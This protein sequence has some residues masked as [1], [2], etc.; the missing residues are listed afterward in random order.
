MS[1]ASLAF[2]IGRS[3][4][5]LHIPP[6]AGAT[7]AHPPAPAQPAP[8]HDLYARAVSTPV[9]SAPLRHRVRPGDRV[10]VL[11]DDATRPTPT[12]DLFAWLVAD[13]L[14]SGVRE[15][16][17][18]PVYAPGL[19]Q[20]DDRR[21][22]AKYGTQLFGHPRLVR[23]DFRR[24][25]LVFKGV[26]SRGV[27]VFVNDVLDQVDLAISLGQITPHMDAGFGGGGKIILPGISGKP[28]VEQNH[29][30][31]LAPGSRLAR[32]EGNPV[33][34]DM[35][36]AAALTNLAFIINTITDNQGQVAHVTAGHPLAAHRAGAAA[37]LQMLGHHIPAPVDI[38]VV[39]TA[40]DYLLAAM[41]PML[42][43]DRAVKL[44]GDI[45]VAA[46][47]RLGWAAQPDVDAEL[48]PEERLMRQSAAELARIVAD[49]DVSALRLA[50]TVFNYRR[51]ALEKTVTLV[52]DRF[53]PDDAHAFGF[54]HAPS[55]Q[56]ALEAALE[57]QGRQGASILVMPEPARTLPIPPTL[58]GVVWRC[59]PYAE[60]TS[61]AMAASRSGS[62]AVGT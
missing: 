11:F 22:V 6:S 59:E 46:P 9:G 60:A 14:A 44:G 50:T 48:V 56:V 18:I 20:I 1:T 33:R 54:E 37:R 58:E 26:T 42:F 17:I 3:E 23:H 4:Y 8:L 35:D 45:I 29:A 39:L 15:E 30:F 16:H 61:L 34:E 13:L 7:V 32:N 36:E 43:G 27:P 5:A 52:S 21:P 55:V 40:A 12:A 19:H 2:R 41:G 49:R 53:G 31:M 24:S 47:S 28:T 62:A 51:T 10:A 57:R 38:A 25:R